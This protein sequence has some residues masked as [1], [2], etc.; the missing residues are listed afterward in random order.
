MKK[1]YKI[2]LIFIA[3]VFGCTLKKEAT[4]TTGHIYCVK[5]LKIPTAEATALDVFNK[6]ISDAILMAGNRIECSDRTTRF[7]AIDI[8]KISFH[9]IG[10]S[11]AQRATIYKMNIR[12]HLKVENINGDTIL[13]K[14]IRETTQYVGT[15]LRADFEKRYALEDLARLLEIRIYSLLKE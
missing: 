3:L 1:M 6:F 12:L 9:E 13:S 4:E 10:Y 7:I 8:K 14:M 15:G 2:F 5:E 11:S